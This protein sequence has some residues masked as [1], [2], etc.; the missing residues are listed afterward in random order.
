MQQKPENVPRLKQAVQLHQQGLLAQARQAYADVLARDSRNFDALQLLGLCCLQQGDLNSALDLLNRALSLRT[1]VP[2]VYVHRAIVQGRLDRVQ[3]A[4]DDFGKAIVLNP[5]AADTYYN[6]GNL[7]R[8]KGRLEEAAEDYRKAFS[9]DPRRAE[10]LNNLAGVL[11][12]LN[13]REEALAC[14]E[15]LVAVGGSSAAAFYNHARVLHEL[16]RHAEAAEGYA[17]ALSLQPDHFDALHNLGLV[18]H[19]LE[20]FPEALSS[21]ASAARLKPDSAEVHCH[22]GGLLRDMNRHADAREAYVRALSLAP[23]LRDAKLGLAL[24]AAGQGRF[25]DAEET[26]KDMLKDDPHDVA[27]LSG[28][29]NSRKIADGDPLFSAIDSRLAELSLPVADRIRLLHSQSKICNDAGHYDK[30]F[31]SLL[32]A[33]D[34]KNQKFDMARRLATVDELKSL[35]TPGFFESRKDWG[36][37]DARPVFIVGLPRSGTTL[38]E[39]IL[40]GHSRVTGLGEL[41]G[42]GQISR[43]L[44]GNLSGAG[45][46]SLAVSALTPDSVKGLANQ[47]RE[48]YA[49]IDDTQLRLIDKLP[50][51]F[52][53]LGLIALLFPKAHIIHCRRNPIDN[54]LSIFMQNFGDPHPYASDLETLGRYYRTYEDV[55]AHW[56]EVLPVTIHDCDYESVVDDVENVARSA[57]SYLGL[58]WESAC[59]DHQDRARQIRTASVWQVRQ[60]IY[61]SSVERWRNYEEHLAP[62]IEALAQSPWQRGEAT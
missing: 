7:L 41:P 51:N 50:H 26:Y 52:N 25:E 45:H 10:Y 59:L 46:L 35:F 43:Q 38:L 4:L 53:N 5:R 29:A 19:H 30:A 36:S 57:V 49:G 34:L 62:L 48:A 21:L 6:R 16:G 24:I 20:K 12:T 37:D 23:D 60:P 14:Y 31:A 2:S 22:M 8:G 44:R 58:D 40:S 33:K 9:I 54:C 42:M 32:A 56:R 1:D 27:A 15:K 17:K 61:K 47:Y 3:Q 28:L 13:R 55:M 39:Q 11:Q 18:Q